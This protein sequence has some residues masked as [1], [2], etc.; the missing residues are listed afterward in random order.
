MRLLWD[1]LSGQ[2]FRPHSSHYMELP[3]PI[4]GLG[5]VAHGMHGV[6]VR[7]CGHPHVWCHIFVGQGLQLQGGC[8]GS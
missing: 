4:P 2:A 1:G 6:Q 7:G 8:C 5:P 3:V